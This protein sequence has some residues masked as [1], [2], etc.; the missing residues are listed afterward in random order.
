MTESGHAIDAL[1]DAYVEDYCALD[2][3]TATSIGVAGHERPADRL[4]PRRLR[5]P[6]RAGPA[7]GRRRRGRD[8]RRRP[9]GGGEGRVPRADPAWRSSWRRPGVNRSRMSVIVERRCTRSAQVFDLMPTEGEEAVAAIAPA[10]PASRRPRGPTRDTVRRGAQGQRRRGAAVRRG[11]RAGAPLDRPVRR[12]GRLLPRPGRPPAGRRPRR[13]AGPRGCRERRHRGV[14]AV[15]HRRARAAG[16]GARGGR[17]RASTRSRAA[18][19]SAREV[20]LDET[21]AWGWDELQAA[22]PT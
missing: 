5:R 14:R 9:R 11:G 2:P 6:R 3:L 8:A 13:A 10:W 21:Y 1:C 19:S 4:L 15:P 18:T 7:R 16:R 20:D 12:G 17:A 22:R